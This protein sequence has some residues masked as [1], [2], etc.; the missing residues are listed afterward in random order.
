[1]QEERIF[2]RRLSIEKRSAIPCKFKYL[3]EKKKLLHDNLKLVTEI[4]KLREE[5]GKLKNVKHN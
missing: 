4:E 3:K 2:V 5:Y 1:M